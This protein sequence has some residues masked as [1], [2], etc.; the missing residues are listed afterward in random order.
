MA[1]TTSAVL[2]VTLAVGCG[3]AVEEAT[4]VEPP[5]TPSLIPSSTSIPSPK[6]HVVR[7]PN[8][9]G[10]RQSNAERSLNQAELSV[11]TSMRFSSETVRTVLG[12][13][14]EPG[15]HVDEGT[16]IELVL[17]KS[18]PRIPNVVGSMLSQARRTLQRNDFD[19]RVLHKTSS[20]AKDTVLSQS[21][22]GGTEV[23]PG[24]RITVVTAKPPPQPPSTGAGGSGG[25]CTPGYSPCLSPAPDYDCAGG[26]GDGP[27]Y[28]G[29]VTVTGSDPYGLDAD[30]DG[31]GCE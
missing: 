13:R 23:R 12:Q 27:K 17:A 25:G 30:G 15:T 5:V 14:P 22:S 19:I 7:V 16:T 18:L 9:E 29:R 8:L 24:R 4:G 11:A 10:L 28:T 20:A 6:T 3:Q 31:V 26:S 1:R 2:L 21:P